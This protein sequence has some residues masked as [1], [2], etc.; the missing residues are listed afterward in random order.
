[1]KVGTG[2]FKLTEREQQVAELSVQGFSNARIAERL[3]IAPGT[4]QV[5]QTKIRMV[6]SACLAND[7]VSA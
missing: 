1:M 3:G 6:E 4:V 2:P 5:Y 7:R